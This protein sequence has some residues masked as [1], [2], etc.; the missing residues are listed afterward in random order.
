MQV[1]TMMRYQFTLNKVARL[2]WID[3]CVDTDVEYRGQHAPLLRFLPVKT[4]WRMICHCL[5]D[6]L[7]YSCDPGFCSLAYIPRKIPKQVHEG[8][9]MKIFISG[10]QK[11]NVKSAG[12]GLPWWSHG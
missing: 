11:F 8:E 1:E 6:R 10:G 3:P 5:V 4:F 2:G 7:I 12:K 9:C